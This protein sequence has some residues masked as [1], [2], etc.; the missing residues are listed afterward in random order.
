[1]KP[2]AKFS[3]KRLERLIKIF[4]KTKKDKR[5]NFQRSKRTSKKIK[6]TESKTNKIKDEIRK[7]RK[8]NEIK[9]RQNSKISQDL[10]NFSF[11]FKKNLKKRLTLRFLCVKISLSKIFQRPQVRKRKHESVLAEEK[12]ESFVFSISVAFPVAEIF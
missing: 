4:E 6:E 11:F 3:F 8:K 9:I 12:F 7:T 1:M 5:K 10:K 2:R